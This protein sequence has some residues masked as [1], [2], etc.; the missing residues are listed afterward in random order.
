MTEMGARGVKRLNE[1]PGNS[2]SLLWRI[3]E[4]LA[5]YTCKLLWWKEKNA[6][7]VIKNIYI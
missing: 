1:N 3:F 5:M 2:L 6:I 7:S 4:V